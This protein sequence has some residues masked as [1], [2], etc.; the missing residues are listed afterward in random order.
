MAVGRVLWSCWQALVGRRRLH[1]AIAVVTV[2]G[3]SLIP[4]TVFHGQSRRLMFTDIATPDMAA[5]RATSAGACWADFDGDGL[6]DLFATNA[7]GP[8]H[9][10]R[11]D[12]GGHFTDVT[13]QAGI[14][15][16][17]ATSCAFVDLNGNG[18][19][20][21]YVTSRS[22][23]TASGQIEGESKLYQNDG[24]VFTDVT[25]EADVSM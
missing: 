6:D 23:A 14:D 8:S 11:N 18:R 7:S 3:L 21:L 17:K 10:W 12:G 1:A 9:L 19:P 4:A 2:L 5:K 13:R 20:D 25:N 22:R 24:G 16:E 15:V